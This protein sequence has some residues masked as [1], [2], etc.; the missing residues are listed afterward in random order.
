MFTQNSLSQNR[1]IIDVHFHT[2]SAGDYGETPPPNPITGK[3]P[4]AQT[5]DAIYKSNVALL[6]KYNVVKAICSG[7]L[8]RNLDFITKD[9]SRFISSLEYPDHKNNSLPDT[10]TFKKLCEE[11]K[12]AVFGELAL[13]YEGENLTNKKYEPYLAICEKYGIPVAVHTGIAAPN[14]PY[15]CCPKFRIEEGRPLLLEPILIKHPKLKIQMMHMGF[16]FL[17]ET[18]ALMYVYPQVYV[19]VSAIDWLVPKEDFY[20]YL[21]S[22]INSGFDTR[23]MY[24]S[25][26]MIWEDAIPLSIKNIEDAP[27]LSDSQKDNIFYNNA[28]KFFNIK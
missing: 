19:D 1:R 22:L 28:V 10:I 5:N 21:K 26:Q 12:I 17:E 8:K 13:Q 27:F 11:K 20:S 9:P 14:T 15:T 18:K 24:G 16:P 23:I 4:E 3:Q 2:R 25:D 7:S 6:I